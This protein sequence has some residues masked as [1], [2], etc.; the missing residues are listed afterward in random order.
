MIIYKVCSVRNVLTVGIATRFKQ[1]IRYGYKVRARLNEE[2]ARLQAANGQPRKA[3]FQSTNDP[4]TKPNSEFAYT[5][6]EQSNGISLPDQSIANERKTSL[7]SLEAGRSQDDR[8]HGLESK[9]SY[10]TTGLRDEEG[11]TDATQDLP[12]PLTTEDKPTEGLKAGDNA[13]AALLK[14]EPESIMDTS[15]TLRDELRC[16]VHFMDTEMK[17]I[18]AVQKG[19]EDGT[20][21]TIAFDYLWL[22]FKPGDLV[23]RKGERQRAYI[24]L[25]TCGGRAVHRSAQLGD[26]DS[27]R[28]LSREDLQEKEAYLAKYPNTS[29]F[30]LDCFYLDFDGTNFGPLPEKVL[31]SD[32]EGEVPINSL[33]VFPLRYDDNPKR[34]EKA[35]IKRGK[36][37]VKL[38]RV[39]HKYYSGKTVKEPIILENPGEVS[40]L[41]L[42]REI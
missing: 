6:C 20:R 37:F 12:E 40:F 28:G 35:L 27:G 32:Y 41:I 8:A 25:H 24:V 5:S 10:K 26:Y 23:I 15:T 1:L 36:R 38:A 3:P 31:L 2:E 39:D 7:V 22:L 29:P 13:S 18:F 19:I 14:A 21:T 11:H 34:T 33:D 30:V 16:L 17:D 9:R 42:P 4:G